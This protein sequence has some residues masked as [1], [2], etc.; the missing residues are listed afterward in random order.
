M[1]LTLQGIDKRFGQA[2]VLDQIELEA[3]SGELLALLGPSGSGKTTLLRIVGGLEQP[4]AGR[5]L[6][7]EDDTAGWPIQ[8]RR[9]GF[10]FQHY[11]LF[12]HMSVFENVAFGL[13][14]LPRPRRPAEA[15]IRARVHELLSLVRLEGTHA[16]YPAQLSGGQ[17][18]RV[19]LARALAI[20]PR[21]L[22]LDEPFGALDAQVRKE[23]RRW[24]RQIH[25]RTGLTTLFVTHD[26]D[27]ALELSD[28]IA[29]MHRGK[30][31]QVGTPDQIFDEPASRFVHEF[32]G[33]SSALPV[34][35]DSGRVWFEGRAL[36]LIGRRDLQGAADL[37][38]RPQHV[39]LVDADASAI[40]AR[41]S[42]VVRV[43][44]RFRIETEAGNAG[45]RIEI[46]VSDKPTAVR[47]DIVHFKPVRWKLYERSAPL[48]SVSEP[49]VV[50]P[51]LP[52]QPLQHEPPTS[53]RDISLGVAAFES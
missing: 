16:R 14:A 21:V 48:A 1:Q 42:S 22:L 37:L 53:S 39:T 45:T 41:V 17:Q 30:L 36:D 20:D 26:Q 24:I 43:G 4:S 6:Y 11:A 38:F 52:E 25:D 15:Q 44:A 19:A 10:V 31:A 5:V 27:E 29:I 23:L 3:R 33:E 34:D 32:V 8:Q 12:R 40:A 13:R 35:V 51:G 47:G 49:P 46:E 28:R 50:E 2:Q 9:V 18:Q 7:G